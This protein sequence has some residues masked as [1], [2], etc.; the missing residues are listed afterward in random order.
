MQHT[1]FNLQKK[2]IF[3]LPQNEIYRSMFDG[4]ALML[5]FNDF[6]TNDILLEI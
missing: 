1:K 6:I 5:A 3:S 2:I 4:I